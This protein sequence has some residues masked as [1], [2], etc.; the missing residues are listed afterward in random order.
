MVAAAGVHRLK[1]WTVDPTVVVQRLLID[2]GGLEPTYLGPGES[3]W[4]G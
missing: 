1:F 2:T 4:V 3:R